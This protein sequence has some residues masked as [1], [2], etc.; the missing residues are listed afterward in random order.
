MNKN[1]VDCDNL[2]GQ[3]ATWELQKE[4]RRMETGNR[5]IVSGPWINHRLMTSTKKTAEGVAEK[6]Q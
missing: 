4:K 1:L 6:S 3:K 5:V 2:A